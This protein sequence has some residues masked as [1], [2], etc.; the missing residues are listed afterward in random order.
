MR[1]LRRKYQP[2]TA[3]I[4]ANLSLLLWCRDR[5]KPSASA[6]E[7]RLR[8]CFVFG[9]SAITSAPVT[10]RLRAEAVPSGLEGSLLGGNGVHKIALGY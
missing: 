3:A 7:A 10:F 1:T 5:Q 6:A 4:T 2:A 9:E 8:R